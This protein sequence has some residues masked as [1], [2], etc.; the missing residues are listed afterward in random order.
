MA[1]SPPGRARG[2]EQAPR[3][4]KVLIVDN[5]QSFIDR[6]SSY[7][8]NRFE[9]ESARSG[10]EGLEKVREFL[11][12]VVLLDYKLEDVYDG[13]DVLKEIK[14]HFAFV[15]VILVSSFLD[16]KVVAEAEKLG[17]DE[18]LPKNLNL[19]AFDRLIL[20]AIERNLLSRKSQLAG[21]GRATPGIA[22]VFESPAMKEVL[23]KL[24][25]YRDLD[26]TVLISGPPGS[27][28]EVLASWIHRASNR[29]G[30]PYCVIDLPSM[31]PEVFEAELFGQDKYSVAETQVTKR[32]LL[33]LAHGGVIVLD[34]IGDLPLAAQAKLLRA[35]EKKSFHRLGSDKMMTVDV[36]FIVLTAKDLQGMVRAGMFRSELYYRINTLRVDLP[37][38]AARREDVPILATQMLE[39]FAAAFRK[40]V[41][42]IDPAV[43]RRFG[44]YQWPGNVRELECVMKSAIMRTTGPR[45]G[46]DDVA[47]GL[48]GPLSTGWSEPGAAKLRFAEGK[49]VW[50]RRY[51]KQLLE[52]TGGDVKDAAA[53]AGIPRESLY[54]L[55]RKFKIKPGDFRH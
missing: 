49:A 28:K 1:E 46:L 2:G 43:L 23:Q 55:M 40:D 48:G 21:R 45:I 9:L 35:A 51:I 3:K 44:E 33:E 41:R 26:E 5:E 52:S 42:E 11:P 17:V 24:E 6:M 12:D 10:R 4:S 20:R 31:S 36:R 14:E 38:L 54:R 32:G 30:G 25:T 7:L 8:G 50:E 39:S 19:S 22:P 18:C 53:L 29:A 34:E 13:L 47:S 27:G 16:E 15:N 37:P